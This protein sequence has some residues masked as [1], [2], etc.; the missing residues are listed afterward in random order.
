MPEAHNLY[1]KQTDI[2][3]EWFRVNEPKTVK[4]G[5]RVDYPR[6]R[7]GGHAFNTW[8]YVTHCDGP[9]EL[10]GPALPLF[11]QGLRLTRF[12]KGM[13]RRNYKDI[14]Q[15]QERLAVEVRPEDGA[16]ALS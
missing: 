11:E 5:R 6:A 13:F 14:C 7:G 16:R 1:A 10:D 3:D 9:K 4:T 15:D 2:T 8:E 12:K